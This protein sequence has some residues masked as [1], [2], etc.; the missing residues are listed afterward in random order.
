MNIRLILL[1]LGFFIFCTAA[2]P[3]SAAPVSVET[4][5]AQDI[6][7]IHEQGKRWIACF[8]A[9]DIDCLMK[10]YMPDAQ[11]ALHGQP[12]LV[13]KAAIRAYF[14]PGLKAKPNVQFLLEP[15]VLRVTGKQAFFMSKYWYISKPSGASEYKDTG[16][17]LLQYQKDRDGSWKILVDMD[18]ATPDVQF[19]AP[20]SAH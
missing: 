19:P 8:K 13:G 3:I 15:E 10:L 20:P 12:K 2:K 5:N 16:R 1:S 17:S 9:G 4:K 11:V 7:A 14:A 18:Q 6:A